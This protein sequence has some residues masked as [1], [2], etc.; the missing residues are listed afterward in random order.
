MPARA[1]ADVQDP[2]AGAYAQ[3]TEDEVRLRLGVLGEHV[4][5]VAARF[6]PEETLPRSAA[7]DRIVGRGVAYV[8]NKK[9]AP[10]LGPMSFPV[11]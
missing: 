6:G 10:V 8:N 5:Q 7:H 9:K 2:V 1:A 3:L 11:S 4:F